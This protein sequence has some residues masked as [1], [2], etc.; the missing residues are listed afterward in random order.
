MLVC[1][2]RH[3]GIDRGIG[4]DVVEPAAALRRF[5]DHGGDRG[6]IAHVGGDREGL[7]AGVLDHLQR[8]ARIDA[9]LAVDG[10]QRAVRG[11][12]DRG[13]LADAG[14]SAGNEGDLP[15]ETSH[16]S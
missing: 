9:R 1:V 6:G 13:C 7:A 15:C 10:D 16:A 11:K 14:R 4:D 8:L 2:P 3:E 12:P 5:L